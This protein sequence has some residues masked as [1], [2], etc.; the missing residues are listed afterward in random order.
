MPTKCQMLHRWYGLGNYWYYQMSCDAVSSNCIKQLLLTRTWVG[1]FLP[2]CEW[3]LT[4]NFFLWHATCEKNQTSSFLHPQDNSHRNRHY[5]LHICWLITLNKTTWHMLFH[6]SVQNLPQNKRQFMVLT[7]SVTR[8]DKPNLQLGY[9]E[10]YSGECDE[11][12]WQPLGW[13]QN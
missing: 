8:E 7:A 3:L 4:E 13:N 12:H 9:D 1:Q 11:N 2:H 6:V 10:L 5:S